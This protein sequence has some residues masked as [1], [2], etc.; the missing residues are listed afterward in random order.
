MS[1]KILSCAVLLAHVQGAEEGRMKAHVNSPG[2]ST[3][4]PL[5]NTSVWPSFLVFAKFS[6]FV[7]SLDGSVLAQ[8]LGRVIPRDKDSNNPLETLLPLFQSP[9]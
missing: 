2:V 9:L 5:P 7:R 3:I 8:R 1:T 6:A 4:L